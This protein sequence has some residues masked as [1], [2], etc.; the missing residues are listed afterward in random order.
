MGW[1]DPDWRP[2]RFGSQCA[3]V[4]GEGLRR[5]P[6]LGPAPPEARARETMAVQLRRGRGIDRVS[7]Q[8]QTGFDL[9]EI[10]GPAI[11]RF[12]ELGLLVAEGLCV[13]LTREGKMVA[14]SV[15]EGLL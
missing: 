7:F 2:P 5:A 12:V 15:I 1:C 11:G 14:D 3:P 10:A 4:P 9:E 6:A 8:K 13:R